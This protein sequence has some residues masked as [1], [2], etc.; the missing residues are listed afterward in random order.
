MK[1]EALKQFESL[2][3]VLLQLQCVDVGTSSNV[4]FT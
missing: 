2:F 4:R 1:F 3:A